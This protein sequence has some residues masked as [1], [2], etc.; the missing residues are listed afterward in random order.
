MT[1]TETEVQYADYYQCAAGLTIGMNVCQEG[2]VVEGSAM[3]FSKDNPPL[4]EEQQVKQYGQV[5]YKEYTP[6]E[7]EIQPIHTE[8][9]RIRAMMGMQSPDMP[10]VNP[11][12]ATDVPLDTLSRQ[13]LRAKARTL[14]LNFP[15]DTDREQMLGAI[16]KKQKENAEGE[17]GDENE[18]EVVKQRR[19]HA[20]EAIES[21]NELATGG[22]GGGSSSP[23]PRR[24]R[25]APAEAP[26]EEEVR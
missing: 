20:R 25:S 24:Q 12:A 16:E 18:P 7:D 13:E 3:G 22:G 15:E 2:E 6:E 8:S 26:A 9:T 11:I 14:G 4:S 21:N 19:Q 10:P 1:E 23:A 17:G 5:M